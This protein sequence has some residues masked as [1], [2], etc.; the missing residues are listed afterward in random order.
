VPVLA[1]VIAPPEFNPERV[2]AENDGG[3]PN[4]GER[5]PWRT[6]VRGVSR[7]DLASAPELDD[8]GVDRELMRRRPKLALTPEQYQRLVC[9]LG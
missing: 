2:Q 4:A 1:E 5:W 8:I 9:A 7:V 6:P 3:E